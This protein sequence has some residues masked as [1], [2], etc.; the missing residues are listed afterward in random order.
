[1]ALTSIT[2]AFL[3]TNK[4]VDWHDV[5]ILFS[6]Q[7]NVFDSK[8]CMNILYEQRK[9]HP[10]HVLR[11]IKMILTSPMWFFLFEIPFF[12]QF[13]FFFFMKLLSFFN[14]LLLLCNTDMSYHLNEV[15]MHVSLLYMFVAYAFRWMLGLACGPEL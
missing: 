8:Q 13:L 1:M 6:V 9:I 7:S 10:S 11:A 12:L 15:C 2:L 14:M 3:A 5:A 4:S